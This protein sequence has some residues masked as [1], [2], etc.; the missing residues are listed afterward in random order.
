MNPAMSHVGVC[1]PAEHIKVGTQIMTSCVLLGG[2]E[3]LQ[4]HG[5]ALA[6]TLAGLTGSVN[7]RGMLLLFPVYEILLQVIAPVLLLETRLY[8]VTLDMVAVA[9]RRA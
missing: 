6:G 2:S 9:R 7:E 4:H 5:A 8:M 1:L 3:F